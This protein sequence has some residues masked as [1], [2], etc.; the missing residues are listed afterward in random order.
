MKI[1]PQLQVSL[2]HIIGTLKSIVCWDC[3]TVLFVLNFLVIVSATGLSVV[4][5]VLSVLLLELRTR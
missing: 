4:Y 1:P 5:P 3:V 2:V